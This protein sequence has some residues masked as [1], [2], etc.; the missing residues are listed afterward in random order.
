MRSTVYSFKNF[1]ELELFNLLF[2][3]ASGNLNAEF[4]S[5]LIF[6]G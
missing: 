5:I 4:S 1:K 2:P 3:D 6:I